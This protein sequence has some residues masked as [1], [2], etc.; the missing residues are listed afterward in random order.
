MIFVGD[1]LI[2]SE[3]LDTYF[4]CDLE[5][6]KGACC[7]EGE[8]GAPIA[9][10]EEQQICGAYPQ[11]EYLLPK[12]NRKYIEQTGLMYE[13]YDGE[14]VTNI[15]EGRECVF[16]CFE[17]DS[18]ARCAFEKHFT[19]SQARSQKQ[20]NKDQD[21]GASSLFY[22]PI[23]CHLFPIRVKEL[24]LGKALNYVRWQPICEP[25]RE[26]GRRE[27]IRLYEFL[28]EPLIR[29]FGEEWYEEL[30]EQAELYFRSSEERN[31]SQ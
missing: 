30:L 24:K 27:G 23:S 22:K 14:M 25:A 16:T 7:I 29:A 3:V 13:D 5:A 28:R 2:S 17:S 15:I 4:C 8:S 9:K 1:I 21:L 18:S 20:E 26:K 12:K 11:V 19:E 10:D 6:C 31:E